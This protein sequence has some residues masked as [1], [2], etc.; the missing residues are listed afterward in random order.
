VQI[1]I[2]NKLRERSTGTMQKTKKTACVAQ[3]L[4]YCNF[5]AAASK[6]VFFTCASDGPPPPGGRR[7][8]F[9]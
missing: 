9:E 1:S 7:Q 8:K 3:I 2:A 4:E 6:P 5:S